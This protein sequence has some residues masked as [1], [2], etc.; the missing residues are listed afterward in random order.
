MEAGEGQEGCGAPAAA[1]AAPAL[2]KNA[3]KRLRKRAELEATKAEWRAKNRAR[4]KEAKKRK[5]ASR[6]ESGTPPRTSRWPTPLAGIRM[7][8]PK[9]LS[10]A[11]KCGA[12][13]FDL[14]YEG[15]MHDGVRGATALLV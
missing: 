3:Q 1:E 7:P 15:M 4:A 11:Q 14:G 2:S 8:R 13:I 10:C 6:K 9:I 12:V 5:A